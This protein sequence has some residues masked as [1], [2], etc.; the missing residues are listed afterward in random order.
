MFDAH[1][2]KRCQCSFNNTAP[3]LQYEFVDL[4]GSVTLAWVGD[5]TGVLL[6]LTTFQLPFLGISFG[7]SRLYRSNN[8]GKTFS[9]ITKLINNTFIRTEFGIAIGPE[10][11]GKVI[12]TADVSG[13]SSGGRIFTSSDFGK[14]FSP[15]NLPFHP[16]LQIFYNSKNAD[17]LLALSID[18]VLWFSSNFGETWKNIHD[19]VCLVK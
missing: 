19:F 2:L 3:N 8:Y 15:Q 16:L 18:N 4:S 11:S 13:K 17:H 6:A 12:L 14:N 9:D 5:G 10:N 7:Q 1:A